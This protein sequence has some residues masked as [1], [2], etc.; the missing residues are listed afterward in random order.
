MKPGSN[1]N[2]TKAKNIDSPNHHA[3]WI[4]ERALSLSLCLEEYYTWMIWSYVLYSISSGP[5]KCFHRQPEACVGEKSS[6][7]IDIFLIS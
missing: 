4:G 5:I 1:T 7:E 3:V 2:I 6:F